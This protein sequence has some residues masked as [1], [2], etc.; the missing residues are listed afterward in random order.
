TSVR[1]CVAA[2]LILR[3]APDLV[4]GRMKLERALLRLVNSWHAVGPVL[5]LA[6]AGDHL[7]KLGLVPLYL[8]ALGSQFVLDFASAAARERLALG[9]RPLE[10]LRFI[11]W[12]WLV[13]IALA[14]V[15]LPIALVATRNH[16]RVLLAFPRVV[17][18]EF[19]ARAL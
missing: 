4:R 1:R 5:V 18:I 19:F 7:P 13:D 10:I 8:G 14:P 9:V 3:D 11:V 6:A 16:A 15:G 2:G 12:A 17:L